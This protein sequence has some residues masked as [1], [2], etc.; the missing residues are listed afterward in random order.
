MRN[1]LLV[2]LFTIALVG[3]SFATTA[4][5]AGT[6]PPAQQVTIYIPDSFIAAVDGKELGKTLPG[7]QPTVVQLLT[8][9][10]GTHMYR[11]RLQVEDR[12]GLG[13]IFR[14]WKFRF[15]FD[16]EP[17]HTYYLWFERTGQE[18]PRVYGRDLGLNVPVASLPIAPAF[19]LRSTAELAAEKQA[20]LALR[21]KG[22]PIKIELLPLE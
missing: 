2:V 9:Q 18:N 16:S 4:N 20:R 14:W 6:M 15:R 19:G 10:P 21:E 1:L 13:S 17:G 5:L 11:A 22:T 12:M 7:D 3:C 8:V